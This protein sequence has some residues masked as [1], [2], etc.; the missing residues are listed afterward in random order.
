MPRPNPFSRKPNDDQSPETMMFP[1]DDTQ[2]MDE[3]VPANADDADST[4][5]MPRVDDPPYHPQQMPT[6]RPQ[7]QQPQQQPQQM[8]PQET[9]QLRRLEPPARPARQSEARPQ[10][11]MP[12]TPQSAPTQY[13]P[14]QGEEYDDGYDDGYDDYDD[15]Y[16]NSGYADDGYQDDYDDRD[17]YSRGN[18]GRRGGR[19]NRDYDDGYDDGYDDEYYGGYQEPPA[20]RPWQR[21]LALVAI[22][23]GVAGL[24]GQFITGFSF[25]L[26]LIALAL[27]SVGIWWFV[28]KPGARRWLVAGPAAVLAILLGAILYFASDSSSTTSTTTS[29]TPAT[30]APAPDMG[31][32]N[33]P[34][35]PDANTQNQQQQAPVPA[36]APVEVPNVP[37]TTVAPPA[38]PTQNNDLLQGLN[39]LLRQGGGGQPTNNAPQQ[40]TPEQQQTPGNGQQQQ[41]APVIMPSLPGAENNPLR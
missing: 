30:P 32:N 22:F 26:T 9:Q 39:D 27:L 40:Q 37:Q 16:Q 36:P 38:A 17:R 24:F 19:D 4:I 25:G 35:A 18:R 28:S 2:M 34:A 7:Q 41:Q 31:A 20:P 5:I 15:G 14:A 13:I 6:R 3:P 10:Q 1:T 11:Q 29:T 23:V 33:T 8:Q 12:P 21:I